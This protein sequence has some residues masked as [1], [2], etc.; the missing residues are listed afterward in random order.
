VSKVWQKTKEGLL[1]SV[2]NSYFE[3]FQAL[4]LG[5]NEDAK[6]RVSLLISAEFVSVFKLGTHQIL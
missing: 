6:Q 2:S 1:F 4:D 5:S 3:A